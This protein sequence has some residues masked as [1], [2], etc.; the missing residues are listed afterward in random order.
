MSEHDRLLGRS[1]PAD[2]YAD[3]EESKSEPTEWNSQ[4]HRPAG[5]KGTVSHSFTGLLLCHHLNKSF[6][7]A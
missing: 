5:H 3:L 7:Y 6:I 1:A 4:H 2:P